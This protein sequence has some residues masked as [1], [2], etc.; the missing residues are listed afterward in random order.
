MCADSSTEAAG[1]WGQT[2]VVAGDTLSS[3]GVPERTN[4]AVL[5]TVKGRKPFEGSNPSP[6]AKNRM[7]VREK[8]PCGGFL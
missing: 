2:P 3:G 6:A 7:V 1:P 5:K 4:G 8:P